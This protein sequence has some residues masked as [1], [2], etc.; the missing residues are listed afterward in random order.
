MNPLLVVAE[1][2]DRC[3]DK[4]HQ[5]GETTPG[6]YRQGNR[7]RRLGTSQC[8]AATGDPLAQRQ[9]LAVKRITENQGKRTP[10]VDTDG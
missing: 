7:E 4:S 3:N 9:T 10:G 5:G 6:A 2:D 1:S 8:P